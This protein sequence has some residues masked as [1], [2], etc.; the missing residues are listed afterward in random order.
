MKNT[1]IKLVICCI[2]FFNICSLTAQRVNDYNVVWNNPSQHSGGSMPLGNGEMGMNV[3]VEE[4]G[5]LLFYLSRTDAMSEANR[6][7]K[8][9]RVRV[10]LSPNPFEK[11]KPFVQT[12]ILNEG[13]IE[14]KAGAAGEQ[15]TFRL[16]LDS[17]HDVAYMTYESKLQRKL[18][19]TAESWRREPHVIKQEES[20]SAY[21]IS[22]FPPNLKFEESADIYFP[23]KNA[24]TWCHYNRG[25][26]LF[27]FTMR[28]QGKLDYAK[29]FPDPISNRI[30]G[31]YMTGKEFV[32]TS[33]STFSTKGSIKQGSL[34][35]T[36]YSKQVSSINE[37]NRQIKA[38]D[39]KSTLQTALNNSKKWWSEFWNRSY[40]YINI[41]G[42]IDFGYQLT[43]SYIL[44]R[45]M[46]A[47]SG[48]GNFPIK[49][50]G[51]IFTTDPQ[52][53]RK[54]LR[55]GPDFRNWGNEFWWQNTRLPYYAMFA[56]G[57]FDLIPPLFDFYLGRMDAFR[58]LASKY[59][60]AKG[61]F[62]P[63]TVTLFGT[64]ATSNYGWDR[65]GL[66]PNDIA[67]TYI[68]YIW[69]SGL[70]L[71]KIMLDYYWYTGDS[72][73]LKEKALPFIKEV[74]LY[75]DS[76]FVKGQDR[77]RI[78][79][80]QAVETYWYYVVNDMP[81]VAGLHYLMDALTRLPDGF[82]NNEDKTFYS[83]L[84][85]TLPRIPIQRTA[86]GNVFTPAEEYLS[87]SDN[88]EN[89]DLY[90][91]WPFGLANFTNELRETGIRTYNQR[92]FNQNT[93][94][95]QDGQIVAMLG[96][97]DLLPAMLKEKVANTNVNHRFPAMWGPNYD[98]VPDQDHG[99]NLLLT[100]QNMLLQ[101]HDGKSHILPAWPENWDVSFKLLKPGRKVVEGEYKDGE[102]RLTK[103]D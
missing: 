20:A 49:F 82:V 8:L 6:L 21:I 96:I 7:M 61:I 60:G 24:L 10:A 45:Y 97:T 12:L 95:G 57:D 54:E 63:E 13:V 68:R 86:E 88:V 78:S 99:S 9:G 87:R 37:W 28:H 4:G 41:P 23:D 19:V 91:V 74:L 15:V 71:S 66:S 16:F 75:F 92:R 73:F 11:G 103:N 14:I 94:W 22:A 64:Y 77:M 39:Q 58:T 2:L 33:D 30:F 51:S 18:T 79:P 98:W 56:S 46:V 85:K 80:T 3:W 27:D 84:R 102:L 62:I 42:D 81:C 35:I 65:T 101:I 76:R 25:S 32:K 72:D 40:I 5:D 48:R 17:S 36:T 67:N 52:Y 29:N 70:E 69:V 50:N 38:I 90:V 83:Q 43:Q 100:V 47:G 44:Q 1:K 34:K 59:Y 89:P 31:V 55:Y 26:E 93:G 53:T